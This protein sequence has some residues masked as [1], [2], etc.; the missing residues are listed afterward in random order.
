M[1]VPEPVT[2]G[3]SSRAQGIRKPG[4]QTP[5]CHLCAHLGKSHSSRGMPAQD[6]SHTGLLVRD[7]RYSPEISLW[8]WPLATWM[9]QFIKFPTVARRYC[10]CAERQ[11][12]VHVSLQTPSTCEGMEA[13]GGG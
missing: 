8:L 9:K 7:A 5:L 10:C 4:F 3:A 2:V 13:L 6:P 1:K 12:L 11:S